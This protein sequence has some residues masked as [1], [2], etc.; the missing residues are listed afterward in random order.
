VIAALLIFLVATAIAGGIAAL[1]SR[2]MG[3]TPTGKVV[4]TVAPGIVMAIAVFMI[5]QEL[6][7][8]EGIVLITYAAIMGS[9][10]LAAALA[11]GLGGRE[12]A[13]RML[14]AAYVKGQ[15]S[16][17]QVRRDLQQGRENAR[18]EMQ[19]MKEQV[20]GSDGER[21]EGDDVP[22]PPSRTPTIVIEPG[23]EPVDE[24]V[25]ARTGTGR[26]DDERR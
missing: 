17:E 7:I 11:F 10:A 9:L 24:R 14:E 19:S 21:I 22:E 3:D 12:V 18:S 4:G 20:T 26:V 23:A 16:R 2:T 5:L 25:G 13:G 8:A 15:E 1:V 6:Q